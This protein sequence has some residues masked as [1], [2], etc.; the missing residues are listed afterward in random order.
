MDFSDLLTGSRTFIP[1]ELTF[2]VT[3]TFMLT[4]LQGQIKEKKMRLL[5]VCRDLAVFCFLILLM[6][7]SHI[8]LLEVEFYKLLIQD[9]V[10][11]V[12]FRNVL[13]L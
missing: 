11:V 3:L 6:I 8:L 2:I 1:S 12:A 5:S 10:V 13:Y 7:S 4:F 9:V